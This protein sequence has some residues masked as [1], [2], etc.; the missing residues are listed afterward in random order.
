MN[1][2]EEISVK[3]ALERGRKM[4]NVP[5]SVV[6]K[7][8]IGIMVVLALLKVV[9]WQYALF[10]AP[11]SLLLFP[12]FYRSYRVT[13][14]KLWAYENV[15]NVHE[16]KAKAVMMG[17]LSEETGFLE[18]LFRTTAAE[19]RLKELEEKFRIPDVFDDQ[20]QVPEETTFFYAVNNLMLPVLI[21]IL[22]FAA[23]LLCFLRN[24]K[25][26]GIIVITGGIWLLIQSIRKRKE[27]AMYL[28]LSDKGI[29]TFN[30]PFIS[31]DEISGEKII[32]G[33]VDDGD[34]YFVFNT[35]LGEESI[36]I[37]NL[38]VQ[39]AELLDLLKIYRGRFEAQR[40]ETEFR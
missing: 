12:L 7:V 5:S 14:W 11:L 13:K 10:S 8:I 18:K 20:Q 36:C 22:C 9:A 26:I 15:R 23:S 24:D 37:D 19:N 6:P 39:P 17:I 30:Y 16:L 40:K 2:P 3:Q 33:K 34:F 27:K 29:G 32:R 35:P 38:A 4:L 31:W 1:V 21:I 28:T 25:I